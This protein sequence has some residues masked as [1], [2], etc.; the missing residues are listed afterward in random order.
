VNHKKVALEASLAGLNE[1]TAVLFA[2]RRLEEPGA[3]DDR[4][5]TIGIGTS[6]RGAIAS[7]ED[8]PELMNRRPL[9]DRLKFLLLHPH[10]VS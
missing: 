9:L 7:L 10:R 1:R 4:L 2:L 6:R 3:A 8:Q 5:T